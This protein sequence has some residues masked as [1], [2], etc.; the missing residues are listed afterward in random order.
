M[1]NESSRTTTMNRRE[2]IE[3][4]RDA[5]AEA[6]RKLEQYLRDNEIWVPDSERA[7]SCEIPTSEWNKFVITPPRYPDGTPVYHF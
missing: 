6:G 5:G 2:Y 4:L 1:G 3:L 7:C